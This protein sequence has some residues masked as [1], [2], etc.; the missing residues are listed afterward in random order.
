M[1]SKQAL[2]ALLLVLMD[3]LAYGNAL[4]FLPWSPK[5][6]PSPPRLDE[7]INL[8][9]SVLPPKIVKDIFGKRVNEQFYVLEIVIANEA[10]TSLVVRHGGV[11]LTSSQTDVVVPF[12][13][14]RMVEASMRDKS[15]VVQL[16]LLGFN[17]NLVIDAN[18]QTKTFAFLPR[19]L[20]RIADK[21]AANDPLEV[22][23]QIANIVIVGTQFKEQAVSIGSN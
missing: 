4:A 16:C 8:M 9:W 17:Q 10:S 21:N 3:L 15:Q 5:Q 11:K 6:D 13:T 7:R 14:L 1:K 18:R 22:K 19:D 12:A 2:P 20:F 23:K